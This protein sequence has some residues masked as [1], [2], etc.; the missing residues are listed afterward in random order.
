MLV[1]M[2]TTLNLDDRLVR[3]VKTRAVNE[4]R[5]FTSLVEEALQKLIT[6]HDAP[7]EERIE[8]PTWAG[9]GL[10]PGVD[11]DDHEALK[12]LVDSDD[13]AGYRSWAGDAAS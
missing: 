4:G 9:G 8:L 1:C 11:L 12:A 10:L 7:K 5:T 3:E 2:R 6:E 13:D